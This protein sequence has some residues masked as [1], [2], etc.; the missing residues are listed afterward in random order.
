MKAIE[1]LIEFFKKPHHETKGQVPEG[2]CSV[3]WGYNEYD[4][5]IRDQFK[6]MQ[7]DVNNHLESYTLL[8]AF[9]VEHVNGVHLK[10][11]Q[12]HN[13]PECG[14]NKTA[15]KTSISKAHDPA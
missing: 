4:R 13:C 9:M 11:G 5:K 3:C 6:D 2:Q 1:A 14:A 10:E 8:Q 15:N 12:I 7:V